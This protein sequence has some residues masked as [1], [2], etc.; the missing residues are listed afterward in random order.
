MG[1]GCVI[2]G[3]RGIKLVSSSKVAKKFF[4]NPKYNDICT[5]DLSAKA[6]KKY[7]D[8]FGDYGKKVK[9]PESD[10]FVY[11]NCHGAV[12]VANSTTEKNVLWAQKRLRHPIFNYI[13]VRLFGLK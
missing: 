1:I 5:G 9:L 7:I 3:N 8:L 13:K 11:C 4:S 10:T 12:Q 2:V 6:A